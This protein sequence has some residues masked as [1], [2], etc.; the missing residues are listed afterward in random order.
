MNRVAFVFICLI[1]VVVLLISDKSLFES[2]ENTTQ[3]TQT[4]ETS[5][6]KDQHKIYR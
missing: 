4:S 6:K 1:A 3:V 2:N 5:K